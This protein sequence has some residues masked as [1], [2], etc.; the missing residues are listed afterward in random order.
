MKTFPIRRAHLVAP[1]EPENEWLIEELWGAEAVGTVGG[2]PKTL[3]SFMSLT[4]AVA[5]AS[6][7]PCLGRFHVKRSGPVLIYAAEDA[8]PAVRKR[9]D[10]IA[11]GQ[12]Q[13]LADLP[14]WLIDSPT[15]RI[16]IADDREALANAV[17][18]V[19]P[20]LLI[21]DPFVRLHRI[22]ENESAY[23][24]PLLAFLRELQRRFQCA[25]MLVH[26]ARKGAGSLRGGQAL[27]GSSEIHAWADA[28][29][30]L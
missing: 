19:R 11:A 5:V 28:S 12:G 26:H 4:M 16:D 20:A 10:G 27:R 14:L 29:L 23:V 8:L 6:G 15:V 3:K 1:V 9:L 2:E 22:N 18:T 24:V 25:V 21:L 30:F 13:A 17:A 7:R